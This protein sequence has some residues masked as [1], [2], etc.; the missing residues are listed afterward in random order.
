MNL[1]RR[2]QH[3]LIYLLV[4]NK[5]V[6]SN[7]EENLDLHHAISQLANKYKHPLALYYYAK[8]QLKERLGVAYEQGGEA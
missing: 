4:P 1:K 2:K 8:N 6:H 7:L 5:I 3:N